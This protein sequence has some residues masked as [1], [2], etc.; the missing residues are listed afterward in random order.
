M[1]EANQQFKAKMERG[2]LCLGAGITLTDS[3]IVEALAP[4]VDFFWIDLE[5]T[6]LSY[7]TVLNHII[8]ARAGDV[9]AFVRVR[10]SD[11]PHIKPILDIGASGII[12]PQ[13]QSSDEV[14]DIVN[15]CRFAPLG[16][17]GFGPRRAANY[18]R[19]GGADWMQRANRDLFVAV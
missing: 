1:L 5:H 19:D 13:V 15:A 18:G 17:R 11:V 10:G 8:A 4:A 2:Q 6:H 16:N 14:R 9:P 12:V 3:A 7:E